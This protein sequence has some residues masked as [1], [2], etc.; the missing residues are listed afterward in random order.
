MARTIE[1]DLWEEAEEL[2]RLSEPQDDLFDFLCGPQLLE[3]CFVSKPSVLEDSYH[4][5][6]LMRQSQSFARDAPQ[7]LFRDDL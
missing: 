1:D 3:G 7:P 4:W 5:P 6:E 2:V